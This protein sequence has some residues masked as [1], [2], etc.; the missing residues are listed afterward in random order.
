MSSV[1]TLKV[2][3]P[4]SPSDA[5]AQPPELIDEVRTRSSH[6]V[7]QKRGLP[8]VRAEFESRGAEGSTTIWASAN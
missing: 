6:V 7:I 5:K 2:G 1:K 3:A 4:V 8:V